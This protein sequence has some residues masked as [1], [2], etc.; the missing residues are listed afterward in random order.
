MDRIQELEM[1]IIKLKREEQEL[2]RE[3]RR[4][5]SEAWTKII[6][7]S[8]SWE[9]QTKEITY[10]PMG[11]VDLKGLRIEHRVKPSLITEWKKNG[12]ATFSSNYQTEER[13]FG[14]F[15]Y[16]TDE[17]ILTHEGGGNCVLDDPKLCSDEEWKEMKDGRIPS[18]FIRK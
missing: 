9:W 16:R 13:W 11:K 5:Q 7:D 10:N 15:Y 8:D 6:N 14:M 17:N 12:F 18:K 2:D 3:E 1:E 4:K